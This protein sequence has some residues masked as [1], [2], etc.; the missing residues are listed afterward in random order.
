MQKRS[1]IFGRFF[2]VNTGCPP[3]HGLSII[4]FQKHQ[5][6]ERMCRDTGREHFFA[7]FIGSFRTWQVFDDTRNKHLK[8][9]SSVQKLNPSCSV[10]HSSGG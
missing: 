10:K 1:Y 4:H 5:T 3:V 9:G 7:L 8:R 6:A 2:F